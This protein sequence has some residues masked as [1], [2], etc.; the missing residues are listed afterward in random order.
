MN[1]VAILSKVDCYVK[2]NE[3]TNKPFIHL[4]NM[5]Y[6]WFFPIKKLYVQAVRDSGKFYAWGEKI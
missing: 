2:F 3:P 1:L 4:A 6:N 5:V